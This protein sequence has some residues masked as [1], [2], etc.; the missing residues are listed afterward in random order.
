VGEWKKVD[1][2]DF[3]PSGDIQSLATSVS[4]VADD[5][6]D[7]FN[8]AA[9][10]VELLA[11]FFVDEIDPIAALTDVIID[12]ITNFIGDLR[13]ASASILPVVP[14]DR[15]YRGGIE[16]F[17]GAVSRSFDDRADSE[18][19][20]LSPSSDTVGY[21]FAY[22]AT[23][24]KELYDDFLGSAI[25]LFDLGALEDWKFAADPDSV[26]S[27][28]VR[29]SSGVP[30][31]WESIR[32]SDVFPP[33]DDLLGELEKAAKIFGRG[34]STQDFVRDMAATIR[35]KAQTLDALA[36]YITFFANQVENL[37]QLENIWYLKVGP[38]QGIENWRQELLTA[39]NRPPYKGELFYVAGLAVF[40]G[41]ADVAT[42]EELLG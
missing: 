23:D 31:D 38:T 11:N 15:F 13:T 24:L 35:A 6:A 8:I 17:I 30:P 18:R 14:Q 36:S 27:R 9:D 21:V 41:G 22:G 28:A 5:V 2:A 32:V 19:P 3:Y 29:Q 25:S 20:I 4:D 39:S 1:M 37:F 10:A 26:P 33:Y 42:L 12:E 34:D 7:A 16:G 40:A